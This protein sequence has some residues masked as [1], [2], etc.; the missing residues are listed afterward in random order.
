MVVKTT[1]FPKSDARHIRALIAQTKRLIEDSVTAALSDSSNS[2]LYSVRFMFVLP[3]L[4][5]D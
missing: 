4:R 1:A 3:S 5:F 2:L